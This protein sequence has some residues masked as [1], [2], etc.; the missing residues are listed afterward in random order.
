MIHLDTR[1]A[2]T[3]SRFHKLGEYATYQRTQQDHVPWI[4]YPFSTVPRPVGSVLRDVFVF[5]IMTVIHYGTTDSTQQ[6]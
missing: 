4:T 5:A 2:I 3:S 1:T 6:R